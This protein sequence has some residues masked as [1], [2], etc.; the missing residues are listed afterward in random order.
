MQQI[1]TKVML[2]GQAQEVQK[3]IQAEQEEEK[4]L[5]RSRDQATLGQT[6]D[7][8]LAWDFSVDV[9]IEGML[10]RRTGFRRFRSSARELPML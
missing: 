3:R 1:D 2:K 7:L 5:P 8:G 4:Y 6:G 9:W 10:W